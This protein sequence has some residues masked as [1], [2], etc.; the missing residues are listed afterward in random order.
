MAWTPAQTKKIDGICDSVKAI[1]IA[2][3]GDL[4][5]DKPG[6]QDKVRDLNVAQSLNQ[7]QHKYLFLLAGSGLVGIAWIS[8]DGTISSLV[9][10]VVKFFT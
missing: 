1:E 8:F 6:L 10:L 3:V 2:I 5:N 4:K 9:K 7:K